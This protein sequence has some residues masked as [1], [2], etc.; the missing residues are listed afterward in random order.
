MDPCSIHIVVVAAVGV[1]VLTLNYRSVKLSILTRLYQLPRPLV[2]STAH[3]PPSCILGAEESNLTQYINTP[4]TDIVNLTPCHISPLP[5]HFIIIIIVKE[6]RF[7]HLLCHCHYLFMV[8][9]ISCQ[10]SPTFQTNEFRVH[11]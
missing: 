9:L 1:G 7:V 10:M 2:S 11:V 5:K 3:A 6:V 8:K 4:P